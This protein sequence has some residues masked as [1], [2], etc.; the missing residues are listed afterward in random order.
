MKTL[1]ITIGVLI[2]LVLITSCKGFSNQF[3]EMLLNTKD[4]NVELEFSNKSMFDF[5]GVTFEIYKIEKPDEIKK[6]ITNVV[7]SDKI[8]NRYNE[9][10]WNKCSEQTLK[11]IQVFIDGIN[12]IDCKEKTM[13]LDELNDEFYYT[14][15]SDYL[16][17][18]RLFLFSEKT[19]HI[20]YVSSYEV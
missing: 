13:F 18:E 5:E 12:E 2:F 19:S 14:I 1:N 17:R 3:F 4:I 20:Y 16:K 6:N 15:I 11:K 10:K 8:Y 7:L 9:F